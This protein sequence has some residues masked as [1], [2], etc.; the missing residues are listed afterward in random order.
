MIRKQYWKWFSVGRHQTNLCAVYCY[1]PN[2]Y[3]LCW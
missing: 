2:K 3:S 1:L